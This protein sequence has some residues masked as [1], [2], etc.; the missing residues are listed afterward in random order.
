MLR[1]NETLTNLVDRKLALDFK[2]D[3]AM[4]MANI[5][6]ICTNVA[7]AYRPTMSSVVSMLEDRRVPQKLLM[8]LDSIAL[9]RK[10]KMMEMMNQQQESYVETEELKVK[11]CTDSGRLLP[12][13]FEIDTK[14]RNTC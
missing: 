7:A 11:S 10:L 13:G 6:L 3:E 2:Q 12:H 1:E 5:A 14:H 8:D 9:T 4:V